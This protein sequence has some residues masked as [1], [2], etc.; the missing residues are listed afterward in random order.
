MKS[1]CEIDVFIKEENS[2]FWR[3][4]ECSHFYKKFSA[5]HRLLIQRMILYNPADK[6]S[7]WKAFFVVLVSKFGTD[8]ALD[9]KRV[10]AIRVVVG[11]DV[12]IRLDANQGWNPKETGKRSNNEGSGSILTRITTHYNSWSSNK[13]R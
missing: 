13:R 10:Q 12:K 1:L 2:S 8:A 11:Y 9:I 6:P 4:N 7:V 5:P 3:I